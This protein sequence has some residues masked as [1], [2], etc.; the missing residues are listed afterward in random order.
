L[1]ADLGS[2]L[3][4]PPLVGHDESIASNIHNRL[5]TRKNPNAGGGD[6]DLNKD[7]LGSCAFTE[8]NVIC[9]DES[10]ISFFV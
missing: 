6:E 9:K 2:F 5:W 1:A 7:F 3:S 8:I 10:K 4:L